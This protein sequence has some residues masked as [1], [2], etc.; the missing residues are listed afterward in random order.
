MAAVTKEEFWGVVINLTA[1]VKTSAGVAVPMD[2]NW[3]AAC[4]VTKDRIGGTVIANPVMTISGATAT[5]TIDTSESI[6]EP[7]VYYYDFRIT[8]NAGRKFWSNPVRLLLKNRNAP[9]S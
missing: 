9:S 2:S 4:R 3:S 5:G 6:W 7:G 1:T 8:D